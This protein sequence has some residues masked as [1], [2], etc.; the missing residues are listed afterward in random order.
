[1]RQDERRKGVE[2]SKLQG[3]VLGKVKFQTAP[4]QGPNFKIVKSEKKPAPPPS[5]EETELLA[6]FDKLRAQKET[7]GAAPS[8]LTAGIP[9][10]LL[11]M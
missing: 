10:F 8:Q 4:N 1:M 5:K 7:V 9:K 6:K 3:T 2:P 11:S